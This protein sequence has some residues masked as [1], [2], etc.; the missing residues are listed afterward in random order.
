MYREYGTGL[1]EHYFHVDTLDTALIVNVVLYNP[2]KGVK[3]AKRFL[4]RVQYLVGVLP[5]LSPS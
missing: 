5:I 1:R 2:N 3:V 4:D